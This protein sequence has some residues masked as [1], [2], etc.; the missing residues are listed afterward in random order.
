MHLTEVDLDRPA[1]R[2]IQ[3][4]GRCIYCGAPGE[5]LTDE[6]VIPYAL[7]ANSLVLEKS[8]CGDCQKIIQ[9]YE[10][11]VL[12][13]Q[14][15]TFRAQVDAPTRRRKDRPTEVRIDFV[16]VDDDG[17]SIR[18]LGHRVLALTEVPLAI[19]LWS[20]PIPKLLDPAGN[21]MDLGQPWS[22][23]D[24]NGFMELCRGVAEETGARHVA[25]KIG[26][27]NRVH[28]L[29][30]LAK[31][32]HAYAAAEIGLDGFEPL[33]TD[34]ILG[35]RDDVETFV[36]DLP[37]ESPFEDDP[38]QTMQMAIGEAKDGPGVGYL[39]VRIVL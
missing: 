19:S 10:Q 2:R 38:S 29:R 21:K 24:T 11:E 34:L 6:H 4:P 15:G 16:E 3:S 35:R 31:T 37:H 12:K 27:V 28:Y 26:A 13:K 39:L 22:W 36:G 5:N 7:G 20:S 8:C 23:S 1:G 17:S 30:S 32:A 14:L 25:A 18:D 9:K 33:L